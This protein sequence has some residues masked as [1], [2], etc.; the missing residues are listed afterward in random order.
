MYIQGLTLFSNNKILDVAKLKAF[1]DEKLH[2]AKMT[3]SLFDRVENTVVK[4]KML[5][6]SI[7]TFSHSVF[8][9]R[10]LYGR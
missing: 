1:T 7:F 6:T 9:C 8:Q 3:I 4:G 10:L 5:I 2:V